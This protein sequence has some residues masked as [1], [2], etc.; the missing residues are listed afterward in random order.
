MCQSFSHKL[1][2]HKGF[3]VHRHRVCLLVTGL[4]GA[5]FTIFKAIEKNKKQNLFFNSSVDLNMNSL[6]TFLFR[7][8]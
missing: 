6:Q 7:P 4:T 2:K 8:N 5:L 1:L 3:I